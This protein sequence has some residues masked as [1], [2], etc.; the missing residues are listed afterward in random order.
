MRPI[1]TCNHLSFKMDI[2][3]AIL[4][5]F[6]VEDISS[7]NSCGYPGSPAHASISLTTDSIR[8]GTIATYTCD[9][10]YELLGPADDIELDLIERSACPVMICPQTP[11]ALVLYSPVTKYLCKT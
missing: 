10:G 1:F 11:R 2:F 9:N 3:Y 5:I 4:F 6:I 8:N 7:V